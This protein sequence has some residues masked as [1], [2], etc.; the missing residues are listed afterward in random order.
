[1]RPQPGLPSAGGEAGRGQRG[2]QG[3]RWA[4]REKH[5][6]RATGRDRRLRVRQREEHRRGQEPGL[7]PGVPQIR[8]SSF[9]LCCKSLRGLSPAKLP[10]PPHPIPPTPSSS[11]LRCCFIKPTTD[12]HPSP[13]PRGPGES[14]RLELKFLHA[15]PSG[16]FGALVSCLI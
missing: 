9:P 13:P 12:P 4:V 2:G 11:S 10:R 14:L 7:A 8:P 3:D 15:S 6:E 1:M 16:P 5:S